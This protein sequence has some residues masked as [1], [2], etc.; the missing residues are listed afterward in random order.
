M[1][2]FPKCKK[3]GNFPK[4]KIKS[5]NYQLKN[6]STQYNEVNNFK[7]NK[8]ALSGS[9]GLGISNLIIIR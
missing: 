5:L 3:K 6:G 8:E 2:Y 9:Q 1:K 7:K 4:S